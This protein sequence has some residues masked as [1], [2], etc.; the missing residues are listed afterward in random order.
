MIDIDPLL[1]RNER[2]KKHRDGN[3]PRQNRK[4]FQSRPINTSLTKPI[5]FSKARVNFVDFD[6]QNNKANVR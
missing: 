3:L 2:I 6:H 4:Y 1:R 5:A